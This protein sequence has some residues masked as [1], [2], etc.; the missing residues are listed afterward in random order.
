M[1]ER[2][3][4]MRH[5]LVTAGAKGLGLKVTEA[6][7]ESG[8]SV[9]VTYRNDKGAAEQLKER[10]SRFEDRI[11]LL[12]LDVTNKQEIADRVDQA[13]QKFGRIDVLV[14]NAGPYFFERKKLLDYEE[15]EWYDMLEGT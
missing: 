13:F 1:I 6:L 14:N 15:S 10:W 4:Q 5:A 11:Q 9:S 7:L 12:P 8:Y 2:G 3:K